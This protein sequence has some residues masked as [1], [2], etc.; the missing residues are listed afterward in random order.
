MKKD[1]IE[2][3]H[4]VHF[5]C[6]KCGPFKRVLIEFWTEGAEGP[7]KIEVVQHQGVVAHIIE[8]I[9]IHS[10]GDS[11]QRPYHFCG[12]C[13]ALINPPIENKYLSFD[14]EDFEQMMNEEGEHHE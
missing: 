8:T 2:C 14:L 5:F 6:K 10:H 13:T 4:A 1:N 11:P 3:K 9:E 12:M 7:F